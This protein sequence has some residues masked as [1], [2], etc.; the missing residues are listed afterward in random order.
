MQRVSARLQ[1]MGRSLSERSALTPGSNDEYSYGSFLR[2]L[3]GFRQS[4]RRS[5]SYQVIKYLL[6]QQSMKIGSVELPAN[7]Q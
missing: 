7:S 1:I 3:G 6:R 5:T 2:T 4:L